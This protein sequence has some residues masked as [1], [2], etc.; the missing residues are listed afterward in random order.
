MS[1]FVGA[2]TEVVVYPGSAPSAE[3]WFA[4]GER[5]RALKWLE[6]ACAQRDPGVTTIL[7]DPLLGDVRRESRY[8]ALVR[9]MSLLRVADGGESEAA[10]MS[11]ALR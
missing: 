6:R 8:A 7:V 1:D 5:E 3:A 11:A 2:I 4:G 10:P 9:Q